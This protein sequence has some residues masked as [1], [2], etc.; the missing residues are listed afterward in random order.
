MAG[1]VRAWWDVMRA[2]GRLMV[3]LARA[4]PCWLTGRHGPDTCCD[5]CVRPTKDER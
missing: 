3:E 2:F 5:R 4:L 1:L